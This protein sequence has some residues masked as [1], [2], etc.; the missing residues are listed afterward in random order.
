MMTR[1]VPIFAIHD[2]QLL[3]PVQFL[4]HFVDEVD[5]EYEHD[6]VSVLLENAGRRLP[7]HVRQETLRYDASV[8]DEP[9]DVKNV[10]NL[11]F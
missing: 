3:N 9:E 8:L 4:N 6:N 5:H 2:L 11:T 1:H 10:V 7:A